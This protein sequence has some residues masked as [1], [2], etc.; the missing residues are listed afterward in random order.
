MRLNGS[1]LNRRQ[2][3]GGRRLPVYGAGQ[4]VATVTADLAAT[5]IVHGAG[6]AVQHLVGDFLAS[7]IRKAGG[8]WL[9]AMDAKLTQTVSR[10]GTG[11]AVLEVAADLYYTRKVLGFGTANLGLEL[12]GHVGVVFIDGQATI[13]PMLVELGPMK[14][15]MGQGVAA[16]SLA[17]ELM[18]SA[19]RRVAAEFVPMAMAGSLEASHIDAGGVRHIGFSGAAPLRLEAHDA[20]MLRQAFIG[21]LDFDLQG[22]G[23]GT[24][25]K[26]TLAGE[27]VIG[28]SLSGG[29]H[30]VRKIQGSVVL[31]TRAVAEGTVIVR[32]EGKAVLSLLAQATGYKRTYPGM[33]ATIVSIDSELRGGRVARGAGSVVIA[34]AAACTGQRHHLGKGVAVIDVI[35]ES[36]SYLNPNA[37]DPTEETFSRL[38]VL[39]E[40]SRS[41]TAREWRR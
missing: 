34:L 6:D 19:I 27:A 24:L 13:H 7:A 9:W 26:P 37:E 18:P 12:Q 38:S 2:L 41:A 15:V 5:R 21:S 25:I 11:Q 1:T 10:N 33:E 4:A 35:G 28:L 30:T 29:F 36:D 40:F 3:N 17:G 8:V 39:R 22:A 20:G 14:R 32:G 31:Q 16:V 23:S